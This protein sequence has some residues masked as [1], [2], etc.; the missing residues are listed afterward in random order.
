MILSEPDTYCSKSC[1]LETFGSKG[2][3]VL[4]FQIRDLMLH[5]I[6]AFSG[7]MVS[8]SYGLNEPWK[9]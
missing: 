5:C 4:G 3:Q 2:L 8:N 1:F 6:V 9:F 7:K